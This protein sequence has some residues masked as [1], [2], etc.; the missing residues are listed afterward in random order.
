M[1]GD[2]SPASVLAKQ[3]KVRNRQQ[4]GHERPWPRPPPYQCEMKESQ[5]QDGARVRGGLLSRA[6]GTAPDE[7]E[8][9]GRGPMAC[10]ELCK[11][12]VDELPASRWSDNP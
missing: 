8:P 11:G 3:A 7:T 5:L 1:V 9:G 10:R 6:D 2:Q 4:P 12:I